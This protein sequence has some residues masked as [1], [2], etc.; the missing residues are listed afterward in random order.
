MERE[1]LNGYVASL[2]QIVRN[3][4]L[5]LREVMDQFQ[6]LCH[7][8]TPERI[9]PMGVVTDIR[10]SYKEIQDQLTKIRGIHQLLEGK[11]RQY[12]R[13]D[14]L[15]DREI[16]E[17][18]FLAKSLYSKFEFALQEMEARRRLRGRG[19][20][21]EAGGQHIP[22]SWF[23]SKENQMVLL[24]NL[25]SL[26]ELDYKTRSDLECVQR[27]VVVRNG[28]RSISLFIL[29]GEVPLMDQ[30]QSQMRLREHDIKE[31]FTKD[32]L[33]GAL[34][35][36]R[37]ISPS[38]VEKL[39]RRFTDNSEF[40][41]LKCLLFSIQSQKDLKKEILGTAENILQVMAEG[42]MRTLSV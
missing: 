19:G 32:Q 39:I 2:E 7:R 5:D 41:K 42:E 24:R 36:L 12:Y 22:L 17:L 14:S 6:E 3:T 31:R 21:F 8:V 28:H 26:Y 9:V 25:Q 30:F 11:Y 40:S 37:E 20:L 10:Q 18:A 27:R 33:R 1:S 34:T 23:Q 4:H 29:S 13:R 38:E 15:R 16:I 35:H